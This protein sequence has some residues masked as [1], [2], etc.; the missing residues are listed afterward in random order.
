MLSLPSPAFHLRACAWLFGVQGPRR[1]DEGTG[2]PGCGKSLSC[3]L[4]WLQASG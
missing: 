1:L 3:S 2:A 4:L